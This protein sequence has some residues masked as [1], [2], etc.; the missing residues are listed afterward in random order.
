M[1]VEISKKRLDWRM[2]EGE[3]IISRRCKPLGKLQPQ[4]LGVSALERSQ[5]ASDGAPARAGCRSAA[6]HSK[7]G[8]ARGGGA[9]HGA[10]PSQSQKRSHQCKS[11]HN[12]AGHKRAAAK[13]GAGF[14]WLT[15][16]LS[17]GRRRG[18]AGGQ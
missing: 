12:G 3:K 7:D 5:G 9:L 17:N 18:A 6:R 15:G 2:Q 10:C 16:R 4:L 14:A 8:P 1:L 11:E 13:L